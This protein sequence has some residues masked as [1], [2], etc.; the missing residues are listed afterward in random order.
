MSL[1]LNM[2][3]YAQKHPALECL[4]S[5]SSE[6]VLVRVTDERPK[7]Q[8]FMTCTSD[9]TGEIVE[10]L[11]GSNL[12][13]D[14][15]S[16]QFIRFLDCRENGTINPDKLLSK[17]KQYIVFFSSEPPGYDKITKQKTYPLSDNILGVQEYKVDLLIFLRRQAIEKH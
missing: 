5:L 11:K 14:T 17:G 16:L 13:A 9:V 15:R 8:S 6:V 2:A 4:Y 1:C 10:V 3:A 7:T 12:S